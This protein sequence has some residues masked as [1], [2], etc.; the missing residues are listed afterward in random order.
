MPAQMKSKSRPSLSQVFSGSSV[1]PSPT[2]KE[3]PSAIPP[4]LRPPSS[5]SLRHSSSRISKTS[6][7][8][9]APPPSPGIFPA[10]KVLKRP[11][12]QKTYGDGTEL[13][14]FDDLPTDRDKESQYHVPPKGYGNRV[15]GVVYTSK[16]TP[17]PLPAPVTES[18]NK[19]TVRRKRR[20]ESTSN[21]S[22]FLYMFQPKPAF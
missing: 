18:D 12:R 14:G 13:D 5:L 17:S 1:I 21:G 2:S 22:S 15:P 8:L 10:P 16:P 3:P 9:N 4:P 7:L 6:A 11:K 19:G 20:T